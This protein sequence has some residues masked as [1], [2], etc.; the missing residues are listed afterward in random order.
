LL[1]KPSGLAYGAMKVDDMVVVDFEE[2][3]L[4]TSCDPVPIRPLTAGSSKCSKTSAQCTFTRAMRALAF[5]QAG[6]G[7]PCFGPHL[8]RSQPS[9][10]A[11]EGFYFE[12]FRVERFGP[13]MRLSQP[14]L[15][16]FDPASVVISSS[17]CSTPFSAWRCSLPIECQS[18]LP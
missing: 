18:R 3:S 5:A 14:R 13:K 11:I 9:N 15:L 8:Y 16:F 12:V 17:C 4:R 7:I 1:L 6:R 2:I 10:F